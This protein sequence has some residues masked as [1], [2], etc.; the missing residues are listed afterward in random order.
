MYRATNRYVEAEEAYKKAI[1]IRKRLGQE[2]PSAYASDLATSYN[3]IGDLYIKIK[4]KIKRFTEAEEHYENHKKIFGM[5][6][7]LRLK[8]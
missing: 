3:E 2:N 8:Y 4:I 1:E 5:R 6:N 7:G